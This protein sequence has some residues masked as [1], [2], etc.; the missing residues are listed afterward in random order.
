MKKFT[1]N[2]TVTLI[3]F[4]LFLLSS[5]TSSSNKKTLEYFVK[6]YYVPYHQFQIQFE[7]ELIDDATPVSKELQEFINNLIEEENNFFNSLG[8]N[9]HYEPASVFLTKKLGDLTGNPHVCGMYINESI[10][11]N[12]NEFTEPKELD[13]YTYCTICHEIVHYLYHLNDSSNLG[14][15]VLLDKYNR[16]VG[17]LV[18][19][20]F[21]DTLAKKF[22]ASKG[23]KQF[24]SDSMYGEIDLFVELLEI[25][26]PDIYKYFF[27]HDFNS[28]EKKLNELIRTN[29]KVK[30][31]NPAA[32]W[33]TFIDTNILGSEEEYNYTY[34]ALL[35]IAASITPHKNRNEFFKKIDDFYEQYDIDFP[36]ILRLQLDGLMIK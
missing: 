27:N 15:F 23:K 25:S 3:Y 33:C 21:V 26:M 35:D 5:C 10:Y 30:C 32:L 14:V 2:L 4:C 1:R 8:A 22:T 16:V 13:P 24:H 28:F 6:D 12:A 17:E 31:K 9:W 18:N 7:T 34:R 36:D 20:A 11:I 29:V 19:E